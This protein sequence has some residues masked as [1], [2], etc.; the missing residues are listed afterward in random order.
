MDVSR[1]RSRSSMFLLVTIFFKLKRLSRRQDFISFFFS[2][3]VCKTHSHFLFI[4]TW[5]FE[6]KQIKNYWIFYLIYDRMSINVVTKIILFWKI[7]RIKTEC[8]WTPSN[9]SLLPIWI[10]VK[11]SF[12]VKPVT[13]CSLNIIFYVLVLLRQILNIGQSFHKFFIY[14]F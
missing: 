8:P 6:S 4:L 14:F 9:I 7:S 1:S 13:L 12:H 3:P 10:I 11:T 2:L 5:C